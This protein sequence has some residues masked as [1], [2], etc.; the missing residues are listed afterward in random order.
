MMERDRRLTGNYYTQQVKYIYI[1]HIDKIFTSIYCKELLLAYLII[2]LDQSIII[3]S[4]KIHFSSR[5]LLDFDLRLS[6]LI[7]VYVSLL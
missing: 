4:G 1:R 6:I 3:E 2:G 7:D 5:R